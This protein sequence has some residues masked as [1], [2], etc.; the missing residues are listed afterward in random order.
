[1]LIDTLNSFTY[2]ASAGTD[3]Q[4]VTTTAVSNNVIDLG[5]D[6]DDAANTNASSGLGRELYLHVLVTT[7]FTSSANTLTVTLQTGAT[8]TPTTVIATSATIAASALP[9]GTEVMRI[10]VP[11]NAQ[12]YLRLN[13]TASAALAAGKITAFLSPSLQSTFDVG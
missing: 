11:S 3:G 7:G 12:R 1:M 4:A 13:F 6:Q 2:D 10:R 8:I 9:V 5:N